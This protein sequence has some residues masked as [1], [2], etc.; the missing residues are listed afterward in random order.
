MICRDGKPS[1]AVI[2][3]ARC[4][5]APP[6]ARDYPMPAFPYNREGRILAA[7]ARRLGAAMAAIVANPNDTAADA[8]LLVGANPRWDAPV[9]NARIRKAWRRRRAGNGASGAGCQPR[10][11]SESS[12][13]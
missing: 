12:R 3:T 6:R 7:A 11:S 8:I 9:L 10:A 1:L 5:L 4:I 13:Q 2:E